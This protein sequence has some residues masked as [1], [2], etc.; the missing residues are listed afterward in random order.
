MVETIAVSI[1]VGTVLVLAGRSFYRVLAGK[2]DGCG[3]GP[4]SCCKS[5][6]CD[7]PAAAKHG[8]RPQ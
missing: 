7:K 5:G 2:N 8:A 6:S 4:K 1:I 3:C